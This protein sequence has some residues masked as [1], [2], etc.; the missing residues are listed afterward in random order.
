MNND[1]KSWYVRLTGPP[2]TP[3]SPMTVIVES[4]KPFNLLAV[5]WVEVKQ[6]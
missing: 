4:S 3:D 5:R 2:V 6:P 1:K